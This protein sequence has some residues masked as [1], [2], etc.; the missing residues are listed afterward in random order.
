MIYGRLITS[1]SAILLVVVFCTTASGV[2]HEELKDDIAEQV[3][4]HLFQISPGGLGE[5]IP[6]YYSIRLP[7]GD[8]SE[9]FMKRFSKHSPPVIKRSEG[10][11]KKKASQYLHIIFC[12]ISRLEIKDNTSAIV[13]VAYTIDGSGSGADYEFNYIENK[14]RIVRTF[15]R[16]E[17]D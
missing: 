17:Y 1:I 15:R 16:V 3:F 8:P 13:R 11:E 7:Y 5:K 2:N 10:S 4:L 9:N 6:D 12:T 14:W